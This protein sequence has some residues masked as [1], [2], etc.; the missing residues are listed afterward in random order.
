VLRD[1]LA[2]GSEGESRLL[3]WGV[4]RILLATLATGSEGMTREEAASYLL[5]AERGAAAL[6]FSFLLRRS[7]GKRGTGSGA[8]ASPMDEKMRVQVQMHKLWLGRLS[9]EVRKLAALNQNLVEAMHH[10][11]R[12]ASVTR[13]VPTVKDGSGGRRS[14]RR[15]KKI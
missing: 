14:T 2:S 11:Q 5:W 6:L 4:E 15:K 12:R 9:E 3:F 10:Q 1:V 13:S 8:E 7:D